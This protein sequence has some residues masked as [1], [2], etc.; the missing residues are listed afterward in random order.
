M[1]NHNILA[2]T[3][4]SKRLGIEYCILTVL[5]YMFKYLQDK[6]I[7]VSIRFD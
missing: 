7:E 1:I 4:I 3:Q 5:L 6:E 2:R